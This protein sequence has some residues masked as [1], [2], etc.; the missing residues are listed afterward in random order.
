MG[1]SAARRGV[2]GSAELSGVSEN[3]SLSCS[4]FALLLKVLSAL[5]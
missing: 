2:G 4:A 3:L 5:L 1:G